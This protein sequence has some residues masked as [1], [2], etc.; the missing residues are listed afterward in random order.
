M[1]EITVPTDVHSWLGSPGCVAG[2]RAGVGGSPPYWSSDSLR[3]KGCGF[4]GLRFACRL[5]GGF[6]YESIEIFC[7][8]GHWALDLPVELL[9][10]F[11]WWL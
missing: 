8:P 6:V 2:L 7:F 9:A 3:H 10:G 4:E 5:E 1:A 11:C